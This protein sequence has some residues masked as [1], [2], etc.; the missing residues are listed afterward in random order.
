MSGTALELCPSPQQLLFEEIKYTEVGQN[1]LITDQMCKG[2]RGGREERDRERKEREH[3]RE[4]RNLELSFPITYFTL[5]ISTHP[6]NVMG[7][8]VGGRRLENL[9][10]GRRCASSSCFLAVP[11]ASAIPWSL[12]SILWASLSLK[13]KTDVFLTSLALAWFSLE[14]LFL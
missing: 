7:E 14:P 10:P 4:K 8:D 13:L 5:L 12:T 11:A 1:L 6:T 3:R 9:K 2:K